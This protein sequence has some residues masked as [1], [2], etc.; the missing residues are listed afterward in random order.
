MSGFKGEHMSKIH[1]FNT[2]FLI[3][4]PVASVIGLAAYFHLED[5][6]LWF[7]LLFAFF[8]FAT[9]LSITAGYHRLFA[10]RS[11]DAHPLIE[12]FY[13]FF[14]AAA[15]ENS[16][17][18][19]CEDHR[20]HH[21]FIDKDDDPY[22]IQKGFW[23]AHIGWI[24]QKTEPRINSQF[25]RDL[26]RNP[27]VVFQDK[28]YLPMAILSSVLLPCAIGYFMGSLLGGFV[29]GFLLRVMVV[30]H[31]TFFINSLCH[32]WGYQPYSDQD[33]S[34]DNPLLAF[35]T[36]GEGYHNFHHSFHNDYRNGIKWYHFDPSKWLIRTLASL[37][38]AWNLKRANK[39]EVLK[40]KL[41]MQKKRIADGL[42][43]LP[44][45]KQNIYIKMDAMNES[46]TQSFHDFQSLQ[47]TYAQAYKDF[48]E[49]KSEEAYLK[50]QKIKLDMKRSKLVYQQRYADWKLT[51]AHLADPMRAHAFA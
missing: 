23:Y 17:L 4:F 38:L 43:H 30:H 29:F 18:L 34:K 25:S 50:L 51:V 42:Q 14:G 13:L 45:L 24:M 3:F 31:F 49:R 15:F 19:W 41:Q 36:Y 22:N 2:L 10:H 1:W 37:R 44:D 27:R 33:S 47:E 16:A 12:W 35:F 20:A 26:K 8:Y 32:Y 6:N 28:Y 9:G 11:Y 7:L 46:L 39:L 48:K 40:A 5:F 21:R